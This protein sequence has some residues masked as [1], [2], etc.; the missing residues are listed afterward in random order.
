MPK[1]II[2]GGHPLTGTV[3]V[4]GSKNAA[5]PILAATL[6]TSEEC[7]LANVPDIAD[8][9]LM[10][11]ILAT[12]GA[13]Y[14]FE[15]NVVTIRTEHIISTEVPRDF[16]KK[17]RAS[18][19]L[20]G[21][22]LARAGEAVIPS[23]GGCVLGRRPTHAHEYAFE[24]MGCENLSDDD[25]L[26]FEG[27]P[28]AAAYNL[29]EMSVTATENAIM[30]AA[31]AEGVTKI[32]MAAYEP[33]V[34]DLCHFL[35]EMGVAITGVGTHT[36]KIV[37]TKHPIGATHAVTSDY[38]EVGTLAIAALVTRGHVRIEGVVP[39]QL[40]S[41]WQKL[42]E[43]GADFTVGA[44]YV[45]LR[46]T[47]HFRA[48]KV[49]TAVFPGFPT[50]LQAPMGVL[51]TQATG[52]SVIF[53]TLFEG[54]LN[55]LAELEKM[56]ATIEILN[57]HQARITGPT[58]LKGK[59][60]VSCDIRAGAAVLVAAL[61]AEGESEVLDVQYIDRGYERVVEKLT[62]LGAKIERVA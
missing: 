22:L 34:V 62:A 48:A 33:H 39:K 26:H 61:A 49:Q 44:D 47:D 35:Q 11:E 19:L 52:E 46:P 60:V 16:A 40:D 58:K 43:V 7:I 8:T 37:G 32:R 14:R 59:T 1:F 18:I 12:L 6:L 30:A 29:P 21:P 23:P 36:L 50:D 55:Y 45:E 15:K 13:V 5:L 42:E 20:A 31:L 10:L 56:G 28:R 17:M 25:A 57:P 9:R 4:S 2:D 3:H 24:K 38:L 54:R 51:L 41:F 53:E 27:T